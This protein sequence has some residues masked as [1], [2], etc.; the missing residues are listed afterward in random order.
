MQVQVSRL[1]KALEVGGGGDLVVTRDNGYELRV[2]PGQLDSLEFERLS[3]EGTRELAA[4]RPQAAAE[5]LER[6]FSLRRGA[7]LADFA[8]ETFAQSEIARLEEVRVGAL[9]HLIEAKLGL[10]RQTEV[11]VQLEALIAE[12]PYR[13]TLRAQLMLA[14]YRSERQADALQAYQNAH[15]QFVEELG[16]EPGERLRQLERQILAQDPAIA[17]PVPPSE[18]DSGDGGSAGPSGGELPTGVV[19]F[20]LTDIEGSSGLWE[21]DVDSMAAALELHDELI[22]RTVNVHA[23]RLLKT[24]G[25]GDATMTAFWRAS[26]A[27]ACAVELQEA[28]GETSWPG[29][30]DLRVRVALHTGEPHERG[31]DYFGPALNRAARLRSLI[32][33]GVTVM[34]QATAELVHDRLPRGVE[35]AYFG[36]HELRGLARPENVFELR[37]LAGAGLVRRRLRRPVTVVFCE[38][39]PSTGGLDP[40]VLQHVE[41]LVGD[42]VRTTLERH[43]GSVQSYAGDAVVAV[44]GLEIIREDDALRALR[45]VQE[46]RC[47]LATVEEDFRSPV[48]VSLELRAG[49]DTGTVVTGDHAQRQPPV[50]GEP[51]IAAGRLCQSAEPGQL[52][53]TRATTIWS[54]T[55]CWWSPR[56]PSPCP[57]GPSPR[58][59]SICARSI[60]VTSARFAGLTRR[61]SHERASWLLNRM[62]EQVVNDGSVQL[63]TIF[64]PAGIGKSRLT[65]E[66]LCGLDD[67]IT[68]FTGRCAPYGEGITFLPVAEVVREAAEITARESPADAR[69]R[70][71][72]LI[73]EDEDAELIVEGVS[74]VL[75]LSPASAPTEEL[76]WAIRRVLEA[77]ARGGPLV[78]VFEDVHWGEPTFFDL[79][80]YLPTFSECC[81]ILMLC[82]ARLEELRKKRSALIGSAV[83]SV[84]LEPLDAT[85]SGVL[86]RNLLRATDLAEEISAP[87]TKTADG[88]PL[89]VEEIVRMLID[90]GLLKPLDGD[91]RVAGDLSGALAEIPAT[92]EA[93]IVARLERLP[94]K[95]RLVLEPAAVIGESFPRS[96][97]RDLLP[98]AGRRGLGYCLDALVGKQLLEPRSEA[99]LGDDGYRFKHILTRQQAYE[100]IPRMMRADLHER[101]AGWLEHH[102]GERSSEHDEL[103]GQH[104]ERAFRDR[105]AV[106]AVDG[107]SQKIASAA[108]AHLASAG[109]RARARSDMPAAA[110]LFGRAQALLPAGARQRELRLVQGL[111]IAERGEPEDAARAAD[112]LVC[113]ATEASEAGDTQVELR[114]SFESSYWQLACGK[115]QRIDALRD[116]VEVAIPPLTALGDDVGLSRA[117][118]HMA[119][120]DS[121]AG[122]WDAAA[123]SLE[124]A[125]HYARLAGDA[126]EETEALWF[127]TGA[128]HYGSMPAA[129]GL[130]RLEGLLGPASG[131]PTGHAPMSAK[132]REL[133][134]ATGRAGLE[135]MRGHLAQACELS[136]TAKTICDETDQALKRATVRQVTARVALLAGAP[137]EAESDLDRS[138]AILEQMGETGFLS[139]TAALRAEARYAQGEFDAALEATMAAERLAAPEDIEV[140]VLW[141]ITK[142]KLSTHSGAFEDAG[143]LA[144]QAVLDAAKTDY[145]NLRADSHIA[146]AMTSSARGRQDEMRAAIARA[147]ELYERKGN[148]VGAR[149]AVIL[150]DNLTRL[151]AGDTPRTTA[152]DRR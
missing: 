68:T 55:T 103:I 7:P 22:A 128:L 120:V 56:R 44:F 17:V 148:V 141:R 16:I 64:G 4:G 30:L 81:P 142:A 88:N 71:A 118:N 41:S 70:L 61:S 94:E 149:R 139:T 125:L 54:G 109:G 1:R 152:L 38:A 74:A 46:L 35:L 105:E 146:L 77:V 75:G 98:E 130:R 123:E 59:P 135:A 52:L 21:T 150:G 34:S 67:R 87:I 36:R 53:L 62:F 99:F 18:S 57:D 45:A 84:E 116:A 78:V 26:D 23:G 19:T 63:V 131:Y 138:F 108:A 122:R 48:K 37:P 29:G 32:G 86:I 14:L 117:L 28:L 136:G 8:Y 144:E 80:E 49:I 102:L 140:Q 31:G 107:R 112:L 145:L 39:T 5:V 25:E 20:L 9:E 66:F 124:K 85:A 6:A 79:L 127:L 82:L 134:D 42:E 114:A 133:V 15:R 126:Q 60:S 101:F 119:F 33:G 73:G 121:I 65:R 129:E 137:A 90:R 69:A 89:F 95:E 3:A 10:G 100:V 147:V 83:G 96:A 24:K 113:L 143:R 47:R 97:L 27:V 58:G 51:V 115:T 93:H 106:G 50:S 91:W 132:Q 76:F 2:E 111:V 43:G 13:E 92:I 12:H 104:L 151:S 72:A 110:S 40:E 11:I